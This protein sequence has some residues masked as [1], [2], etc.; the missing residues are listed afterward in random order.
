MNASVPSPAWICGGMAGRDADGVS[1]M[2]RR[3][4]WTHG[5]VDRAPHDD[6][7]LVE[8]F[9]Q[10][11]DCPRA[12]HA[13]ERHCGTGSR[14]WVLAASEKALAVE[15]VVEVWNAGVAAKRAVS[16]EE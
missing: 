9:L 11:V 7:L 4:E 8:R 1:G 5:L 2:L 10:R 3:R 15:D 13:A 12:S 16:F 14:L 6:V